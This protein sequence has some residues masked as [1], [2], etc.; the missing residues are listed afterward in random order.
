[1][2]IFDRGL[3]LGNDAIFGDSGVSGRRWSDRGNSD[4]RKLTLK[5]WHRRFSRWKG[6]IG[7]EGPSEGDRKARSDYATI[8]LLACCSVVTRSLYTSVV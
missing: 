8:V 2:S 5:G 3:D 1:M 4:R 6:D 7:E